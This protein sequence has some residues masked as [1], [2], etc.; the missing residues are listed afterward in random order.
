MRESPGTELLLH[1]VPRHG[2]RF[3][4]ASDALIEIFELGALRPHEEADSNDAEYHGE[5]DQL[6]GKTAA[7]AP[8]ERRLRFGTAAAGVAECEAAEV[9][10]LLVLR[11]TRIALP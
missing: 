9:R 5:H 2:T 11:E 1:R 6:S 8:R 7:I 4:A 10:D 3:R